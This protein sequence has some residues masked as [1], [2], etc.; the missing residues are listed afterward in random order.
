MRPG[1]VGPQVSIMKNSTMIV[2]VIALIVII[3]GTAYFAFGL[4]GKASPGT[5]NLSLS[6]GIY[7]NDSVEMPGATVTLYQSVQNS[8]TGGWADELLAVDNNPQLSTSGHYSYVNLSAGRYNVTAEVSGHSSFTIVDLNASTSGVNITIPNCS[9]SPVGSL[10]P[11]PK[12]GPW[13]TLYG[14]VTGP[15]GKPVSNATVTLWA[16]VPDASGKYVNIGKA[17]VSDSPFN[18]SSVLSNPVLSSDGNTSE[19]GTYTF[20]KVPWG[21]Y[22]VTAEKDGK[23]WSATIILGPKGVYGTGRLDLCEAGRY[24][25]IGGYVNDGNGMTISNASVTIYNTTF[26]NTTGTYLTGDK[27]SRKDNPQW[28]NATNQSSPGTYTFYVVP[29]GTYKVVAE[30]DGH[31][32]YT[33]FDM[34]QTNIIKCIITIPDY[35]VNAST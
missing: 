31:T 11:A 32:G 12:N 8:T 15:D 27:L 14:Q 3:A 17:Q 2:G 28:T 13:A 7:G 22:N 25:N 34:N 21:L 1:K 9:Y 35:A 6:G 23:T 16:L 29:I 33:I 4:P 5:G 30:A 26:D 19:A 24:D 18:N 10:K 20:Y